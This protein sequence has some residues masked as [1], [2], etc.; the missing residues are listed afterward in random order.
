LSA[1]APIGEFIIFIILLRIWH[2]CKLIIYDNK[3]N[4]NK[5]KNKNYLADKEVSDAGDD[6]LAR[7]PFLQ[8]LK[9]AA[10]DVVDGV[11]VGEDGCHLLL[12][13]QLLLI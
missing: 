7:L 12:V 3:N 11:D 1:C 13:Q 4:K 5:N 10:V 2:D 8:L 6:C 9:E